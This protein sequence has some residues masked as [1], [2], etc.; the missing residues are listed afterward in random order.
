MLASIVD[1]L[2]FALV[3]G[4]VALVNLLPLKIRLQCVNGLLFLVFRLIPKYERIG[5]RNLQSAF[6]EKSPEWHRSIFRDSIRSFG[7]IFVDFT[8]LHTLDQQWIRSHVECSYLET[9]QS[10]KTEGPKRG[11]IFATGHLGSFEVLAHCVPIYGFPISFV[12]RSF[13]L[14]KLDRWWR[15]KREAFGNR[16]ID[17]KGAFQAVMADLAAGRDVGILFDQNVTRNHAVFVDFFGRPT[18]TTKM[19]GI[20]ALRTEADVLVTSITHLGNDRYRINAVPCDFSEIYKSTTLT[21]EQKIRHITQHVTTEY[22][23]MI[24]DNPG[25]W[26]W[27]HRRWKTTPE[28]VPEDFYRTP[29]KS[30]S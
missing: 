16:V 8:R 22:E 13:K 11:M 23:K 5:M 28:G 6:P 21:N 27:M 17:R 19:V 24:R 7:R 18:A 15:Q 1:T 30:M 25:E 29:V 10:L 14:P 3:R 26:F 9:Y 20:A 12:V 2:S 4:F